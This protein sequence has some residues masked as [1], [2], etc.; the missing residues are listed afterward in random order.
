MSSRPKK[1]HRITVS[2]STGDY[3]VLSD[4]SETHDVSASWLVRYALSEFLERLEHGET[5]LLLP[6]GVQGGGFK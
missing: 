3:D 2:L 6:L 1:T 4:L 5:Q